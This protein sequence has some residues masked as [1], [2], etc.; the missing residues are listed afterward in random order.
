M[1]VTKTV[2]DLYGRDLAG[3]KIESMELDNRGAVLLDSS[4]S[5]SDLVG[6]KSDAMER[7]VVGGGENKTWENEECMVRE[8]WENLEAT[9]SDSE[10]ASVSEL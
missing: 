5:V 10:L 4:D 9:S 2:S 3:G 6:G 1:L 7:F 8:R